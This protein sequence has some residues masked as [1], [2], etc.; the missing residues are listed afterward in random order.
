ML[1][2]LTTPRLSLRPFTV[3]DANALQQLANDP[4][5]T[6]T[7]ATLPYPYGLHHAESWIAIHDDLYASGRAMPLAVTTREGEL[8]GTM[9]FAA[10]SWMH[11]RAALAYWIGSAHWGRG[12]ATEAAGALV[13]YGFADLK[14]QRIWAECFTRNP[15]SARVLEK[16]GMRYEGCLRNEFL[17]HGVFEDMLRYGLLAD[18][19]YA[20]FDA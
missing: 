15:A 14:L 12:Y 7:T 9:G 19:W 16:V 13:A 1:P 6:D 4:L 11:Q 3:A 10:L 18:E 17:K 2:T 8:L 20:Q 5:V